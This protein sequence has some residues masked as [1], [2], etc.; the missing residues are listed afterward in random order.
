[1]MAMMNK[2]PL[3]MTDIENAGDESTSDYSLDMPVLGCIGV[4]FARLQCLLVDREGNF[5]CRSEG[6][7]PRLGYTSEELMAM[8]NKTPLF[9]TDIENA[10]DESTSDYSLGLKSI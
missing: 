7:K 4:G 6:V 10:G 1:L 2:T 5:V 9:M 3:F 8:M